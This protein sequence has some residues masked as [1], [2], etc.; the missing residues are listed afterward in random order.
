MAAIKF[1]KKS[2]I[3]EKFGFPLPVQFLLDVAL[4]ETNEKNLTIWH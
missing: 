4:N 3:S 2:R 1:G